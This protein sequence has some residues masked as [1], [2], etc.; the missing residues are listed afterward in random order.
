MGRKTF[1]RRTERP[2]DLF[3]SAPL[4]SQHVVYSDVKSQIYSGRRDDHNR[5][6]RANE[7]A[8]SQH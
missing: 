6:T 7:L 4:L 1:V 3:D 5:V 2:N 8:F